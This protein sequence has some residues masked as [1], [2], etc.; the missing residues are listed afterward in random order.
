[1]THL[2]K[3]TDGISTGAIVA[4]VVIFV[5]IIALYYKFMLG[6][7][8]SKFYKE[9]PIVGTI[10]GKPVYK[11]EV[12]NVVKA[13]L[14]NSEK[15]ISYKDL[16]EN[17]KKMI[18][19][20]IAAQRAMLKEAS[21]KGVKEDT[22][23]KRKLFELKNK[24]IIDGV[25]AKTVAPEITQEKMLARYDEIEKAIKGK[26]QIKVSHILLSSEED[27]QNAVD[28]LKKDPFAKVAKDFSQDGS[29]KDKGGDLGYILAGTMDPDFEK[30]ALSLKVGEVSAPVKTKFGW[31]VI[32][33][34]EKKLATVAPFEA[35]KPH[36]AQDLYNETL[37]KH[38]DSL[39]E[40]TKIELVD[41][42]S[43]KKDKPED[44][45]KQDPKKDVKKEE[46]KKEVTT[47]QKK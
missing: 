12:E 20:E 39:L 22:E 46:D 23:L 6:Q 41:T 44:A 2:K 30:A 5:V 28:R 10:D 4:F 26:Q 34:E 25:I 15:P 21:S 43:G 37:K 8:G 9:T 33:L 13:V 3:K 47:E 24:L 36:I 40:K 29:T 11:A 1:M 14:A 17:S 32:K 16:D 42:D 35:L 31:H 19:R 45:K 38:A 27:T 18:V 7:D